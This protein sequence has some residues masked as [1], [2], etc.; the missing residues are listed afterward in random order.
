VEEIGCRFS[1][2][3]I[4]HCPKMKDSLAEESGKAAIG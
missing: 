3:E 4:F 2:L 1:Q